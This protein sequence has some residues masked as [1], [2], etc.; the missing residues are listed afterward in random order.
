VFVLEIDDPEA[1]CPFL[2]PPFNVLH[3]DVRT[4]TVD[5]WEQELAV[6]KQ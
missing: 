6:V 3:W 4:A 2:V 5:Y 1:L